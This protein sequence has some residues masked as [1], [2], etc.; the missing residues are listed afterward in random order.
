MPIIVTPHLPQVGNS[1]DLQ[2]LF[3]K[4]PTPGDVCKSPYRDSKIM[5]TLTQMPQPWGQ[6]MLTNCYKSVPIARP[7]VG[8]D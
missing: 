8:E 6:I 5:K 3:D 1:G 2:E 7:R 4:F